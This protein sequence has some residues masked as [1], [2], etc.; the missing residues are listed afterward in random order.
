MIKVGLSD[1]LLPCISGDDFSCLAGWTGDLKMYDFTTGLPER[2]ELE[3]CV[4]GLTDK[5]R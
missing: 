1:F 3:F 4:C 2:I 5:D